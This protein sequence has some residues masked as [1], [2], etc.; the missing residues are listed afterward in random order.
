MCRD[1]GPLGSSDPC[2]L[3]RFRSLLIPDG[4]QLS[5]W[6]DTLRF[7]LVIAKL[8]P[9]IQ[10]GLAVSLVADNVLLDRPPLVC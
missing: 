7:S 6:G 5:S 8:D 3:W 10:G 2:G 4:A 1:G 9:G